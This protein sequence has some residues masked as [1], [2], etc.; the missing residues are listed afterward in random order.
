MKSN[1]VDEPYKSVCGMLK[2]GKVYAPDN[3]VNE[4]VGS[5]MDVF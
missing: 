2:T 4:T 5:S 3:R 1:E